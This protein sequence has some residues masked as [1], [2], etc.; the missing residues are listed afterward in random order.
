MS[1]CAMIRRNRIDAGVPVQKNSGIME[2]IDQEDDWRFISC[3]NSFNFQNWII[4]AK[5]LE[6]T[7]F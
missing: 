7:Q 4:E 5:F 1:D 3:F 6:N 2:L